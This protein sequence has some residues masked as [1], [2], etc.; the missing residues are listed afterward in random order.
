MSKRRSEREEEDDLAFFSK[1][2]RMNTPSDDGGVNEEA[3]ADQAS[4]T[5][6]LAPLSPPFDPLDGSSMGIIERVDMINFMC[7]CNLSINLGPRMNFIIGHNGSGKSAILTALTIALGGKAS[8]T[9]RG[10]S[11]R[12]L[13][14]EGA[15]AAEV[16]VHIRN[17]GPDAFRPALYGAEITVERRILADGSGSWKMRG[18]HGKIISTKREELDAICDHANIQVDNPM[19]ILTQDSARQFLG[20]AAPEEKYSFFLR[21]TQLTQLAQEYEMIQVNIQRMKRVLARTQEVLP[22]LEHEAREANARWRLVEQARREQDKL[23][24]LKDELVWSQVIAKEQQLA[25]AAEDLE[26]ERTK[27]RALQRKQEED[28]KRASA[29]DERIASLEQRNT[30]SSERETHLQEQRAAVMHTVK[31]HRNMLTSIKA[32]EKEVNHQAERVRQT[33]Q[34]FQRQI[35]AESRKLE[36]DCR[37]VRQGQESRRDACIEQRIENEMLQVQCAETVEELELKQQSLGE[38]RSAMR[39]E[40]NVMDEKAAH[41]Q[42]FIRRCVDAASNRITAFGG[43][44]MPQVLAEIDKEPRWH[45]KP[46]GPI[47]LHMRLRDQRWAPVME[48]VL[49]DALNAFCVTDHHDRAMLS[50]ILQRYDVRSQIFTAAPDLFEYVH[51]EPDSD[52]LTVLRALE[53]DDE[54]IVRALITGLEIE[55]CALVRQRAEGDALLRRNPRNVIRCYSMDL[56]RL[57]GGARG[58]ATQT[59]NRATGAPRLV[60]DTSVQISEA[61]TSLEHIAAAQGAH[62]DQLRA[63][64]AEERALHTQLAKKREEHAALR[65][66]H[67]TLRTNIAQIEEEMREDEPANMAALEEARDDAEQEMARIVEQFKELENQKE[68]QEDALAPHAARAEN[69]REQIDILGSEHRDMETELQSIFSERVKLRRNDEYWTGQIQ[70]KEAAMKAAE[71]AEATL[72]SLIDEWTQQA[73]EYCARVETRRSAEALERQIDTIERQLA[74]AESHSDMRLEEVVLDL[75]TKKKAYQDAQ[76]QIENLCATIGILDT[77]IH[78]RLEKWHYFRR[79]VAIRARTNFSQ[80]LQTRGFSGSLHFDHNA[81]TLDLRVQTDDS[82]RMHDKDPKSLSGGEKSFSTICLLLSLWQAIGCP[83][84]CLDEFD[85]DAAKSSPDVQYVLITPQNMSNVSLG[86]EVQVHRM[87][88]PERNVS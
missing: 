59:L 1:H 87:R 49:N 68:T 55:K 28:R 19:N 67:R 51:G 29:L 86:P 77:A 18:E 39:A 81:Q 24:S 50:R 32:Q 15:S 75:R 60:T 44:A 9:N 83:I 23:N 41:L 37:A 36:Q 26:R 35:D 88:D 27:H 56:F 80:Y 4:N 33:M 42:Q 65:A 66:A 5:A 8:T 74:D 64:S 3:A 85:I 22:D 78:T 13:I 7:H 71:Q 31:E 63:M 46:L 48:A 34:H 17:R 57:T 62:E 61:R 16:R 12:D 52:I 6:R 45:T 40:R 2:A 30:E 53:V 54:Y 82:A 20:N 11:I 21:G 84:R 10:S 25:Q 38:K 58:S 79:I 70:T 72:A 69:L 73:L 43:R 14:R 76:R 47:G